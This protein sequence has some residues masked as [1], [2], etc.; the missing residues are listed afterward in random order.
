M[1]KVNKIAVLGAGGTGH[2]IAAD[3][4]LAGY[5]ITL[6]EEPQ[7][8]KNLEG[9]KKCGGIKIK[10]FAQEGFAQVKKVTTDIKEALKNAEIILVSVVASR[11]EPIAELC[12]PNLE[13]GQTILIGPDNGGSLV[14]S[15]IFKKK[16]IKKDIN[17][18]GIAGNFYPCRLT[19]PGE[20]LVALPK[21]TKKIAAFPA[22]NTGKVIKKLKDIY[23]F[24]EATNALEVALN[25]FNIVIHLPASLLNTGAIEKYNGKFSLFRQGITPSVM[26]CIDALKKERDTLFQALGFT[27]SSSDFLEKVAKQSEFPE[28][29]VFRDLVGPTSMQHR[30]ITEDAFVG[31]TLMVSLGEMINVPTPISKALITLASIINQTDYLKKGRTVERLELSGLDID[32]LN[33]FLYEG[34]R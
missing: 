21:S 19:G 28:L 15:N 25:S 23:K 18:A 5:E 16:G 32:G 17:I 30:Y 27:I 20:V 2:A 6:F 1:E 9:I 7:Y 14:F 4:T 3:L 11:H 31:Q 26:K 13:N 34:S 8:K 10:G 33:R 12:A 24:Q 22:K 29:D